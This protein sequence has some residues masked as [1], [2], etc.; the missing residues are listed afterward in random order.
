MEH[1][2]VADDQVVAEILLLLLA[3]VVVFAWFFHIFNRD[4]TVRKYVPTKKSKQTKVQKTQKK[5][6][7]VLVKRLIFVS[8]SV[9]SHLSN[10]LVHLYIT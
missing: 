5:C 7:C 2:P 6:Q 3:L 4:L 1:V 9:A 8:W 10:M